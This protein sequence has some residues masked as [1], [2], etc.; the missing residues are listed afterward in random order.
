[1]LVVLPWTARSYRVTHEF[2][3]LTTSG[4][5]NL[6]LGNW[7]PFYYSERVSYRDFPVEFAERLTGRKGL[8]PGEVHLCEGMT[9]GGKSEPQLDRLFFAEGLKSMR[10]DPVTTLKLFARKLSMMWF[11]IGQGRQYT[12]EG[13]PISHKIGKSQVL[14]MWVMLTGLL[15]LRFKVPDWRRKVLPIVLLLVYWTAVY[16]VLVAQQR[17][18]FPVMPYLMMLSAFAV[19]HVL[20]LDRAGGLGDTP[21]VRS[22]GTTPGHE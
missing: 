6:W 20:K 15:S 3:L 9:L 19:C 10:K 5:T 22:E 2:V 1:M 7:A 12:A 18:S 13:K 17:Y 16:V 14:A 11:G 8:K 21:P 4:G